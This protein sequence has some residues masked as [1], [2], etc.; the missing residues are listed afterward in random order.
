MMYAQWRREQKEK[1]KDCRWFIKSMCEHPSLNITGIYQAKNDDCD[2]TLIN[3]KGSR[4]GFT[5]KPAIEQMTQDVAENGGEYSFKTTKGQ[6][7]EVH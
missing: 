4:R 7:Q 1:C 3:K 6:V 5:H 2:L